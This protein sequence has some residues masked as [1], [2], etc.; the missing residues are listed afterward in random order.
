MNGVGDART[1]LKFNFN[2]VG[3]FARTP[4]NFQVELEDCKVNGAGADAK[5]G[6]WTF[7]GCI[8]L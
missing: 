5:F 3:F 4:C 1:K 8:I 2:F 7:I 6:C